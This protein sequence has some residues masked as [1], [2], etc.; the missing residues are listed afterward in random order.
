M[1]RIIYWL[2]YM[3]VC[4][5]SA[6][7]CVFCT[8]IVCLPLNN[9]RISLRFPAFSP[10]F[11]SLARSLAHSF[12]FIVNQ[13]TRTLCLF[14]PPLDSLQAYARCLFFISSVSGAWIHIQM[15]AC[16]YMHGIIFC[17]HSAYA[18]MPLAHILSIENGA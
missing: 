6:A 16:M 8:R 17:K 11:R 1:E 7:V 15:H 3:R 4:V 14:S 10:I 5:D 18:S 9:K 13:L 12:S 2:Q